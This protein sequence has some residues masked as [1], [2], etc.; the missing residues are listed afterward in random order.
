M[1]TVLL[2]FKALIFIVIVLLIK[3]PTKISVALFCE[4][5]ELKCQTYTLCFISFIN[6]FKTY[7][8]VL[9]KSR[10]YN[11]NIELCYLVYL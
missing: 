3:K 11:F 2:L 5:V 10:G 6:I 9:A 4:I 1:Y 8:N 7:V